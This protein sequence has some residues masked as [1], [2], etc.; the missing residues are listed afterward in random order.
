M[1]NFQYRLIENILCL[2]QNA[3]KVS[4]EEFTLTV[5]SIEVYYFPFNDGRCLITIN[6]NGNYTAYSSYYDFVKEN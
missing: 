4:R 1:T 6:D 5:G 2:A 3:S